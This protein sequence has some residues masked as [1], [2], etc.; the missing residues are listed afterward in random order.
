MSQV[1]LFVPKHQQDARKNLHEFID[2]CRYRLTVFG[3][4]LNWDSNAWPG[5]GNFTVI[6]APSRGF[7]D[8]QLLN[9]EILP[10]AKA[11]VRYSQGL[12][13]VKVVNEF[14]ALRCIEKALLISKGKADI[15]L[16]D[17]VVLD[18]ANEVAKEYKSTSYQAGSALA[19]LVK[20]LNKSKI[21]AGHLE[22]S[23]PF[24]KPLEIGRTDHDSKQ[25]SADKLPPDPHL[26]A[27]AEMFSADFQFS[28]DRFTT[29]TFALLMCAPSRITEIQDLPANCLHW[30]NDSNGV[31]RLGL[32]FYAGKGY[33]SDIKYVHTAFVEIAQEAVRRLTELSEEGRKLARW[34]EEHPDKFYRH[35]DCPGVAETASLTAEQACRA[36]GLSTSKP[37][38]SL[39]VYF[40]KYE[41]Y[42]QLRNAGKPLTLAFLNDFCHSVLPAGWP[43][44]N[45]ERGIKYSKA[46]CCFRMHELR[47]DFPAS[48]IRLWSPGKS[49]FTTDLNHIRGQERSIWKRHG[50]KNADGSEISMRSHQVRHFLNTAAQRGEMGQLD[51]AKWSGRADIN[52]NPTYNHMD[53]DEYVE[54]ARAAGVGESDEPAAL[55]AK[56]SVNAPVTLKDLRAIGDAIAH[57]TELGF[58]VHDYS[59][60][61]CQKCRDCLNCTEHVCVKGD[62]VKLQRMKQQRDL[63]AEQL[64]RARAEDVAGTFGADRWSSHHLRTLERLNQLIQIME[65]PEL[66]DGDL[67]RLS[68]DQEFSPI[69]RELAARRSTPKITAEKS[70]DDPDLEDLRALLEVF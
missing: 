53:D 8:S 22:Y 37:L 6:G 46:L 23:N 34:Y 20:F 56:V 70:E 24:S 15:N 45:E 36:L 25:K 64:D 50:Y 33:A 18:V 41:P 19:K 63:I 40:G 3:A 67:I 69:K 49:T 48:P 4:N 11:Y 17:H 12:N 65:S 54:L 51:I 29:S 55:I 39:Q 27:M 21:A 57:V 52:Q 47:E 7:K 38:T 5:V 58:C 14:K 26:E 68:N 43:W 35:E 62:A 44:L 2:M 59:M 31:E 16:V 28:R 9:T 30:Q 60:M 42:V 13:R 10:F 66:S 1:L 61:P 32:R